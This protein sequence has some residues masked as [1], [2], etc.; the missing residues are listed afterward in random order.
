MHEK[1]GEIR[2]VNGEVREMRKGGIGG[3]D[4]VREG[5]GR[6]EKRKTVEMNE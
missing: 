2:N 4:G 1:G 5:Q 3:I 6:N